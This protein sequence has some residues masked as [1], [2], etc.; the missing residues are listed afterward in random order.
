MNVQRSCHVASF[1][2]SLREAVTATTPMPATAAREK[3]DIAVK[4]GVADCI[5]ASAIVFF[6]FMRLSMGLVGKRAS[7]KV[8]VYTGCV[9]SHGLET[10]P[11]C[12]RRPHAILA[13]LRPRDRESNGHVT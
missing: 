2:S 7:S 4:T 3:A 8:G 12:G 11:S 9:A 1:G 6:S 10:C 13:I 5:A